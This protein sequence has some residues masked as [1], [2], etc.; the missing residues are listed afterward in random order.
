MQ[1][2]D[3]KFIIFYIKC[4]RFCQ[5]V[6][7]SYDLLFIFSNVN[8]MKIFLYITLVPNINSLSSKHKI[9]ILLYI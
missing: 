7:Y 1:K 5:N 2:F 9:S 3:S 8:S 6:N 4:N